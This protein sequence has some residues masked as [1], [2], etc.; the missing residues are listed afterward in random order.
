MFKYERNSN[1]FETIDTEE[2]AYWLGFLYADGYVNEKDNLIIVG[3]K[4]EDKEHI[5]KFQSFLQTN[6]PYVDKVNNGGR[7]YFFFR[8][9]DNKMFKDLYTQG[10][11]NK[12]YLTLEHNFNMPSELIIHWT[13][14]LFDGDGSIYP[15]TSPRAHERYYIGLVGTESI[16]KYTQ[17][18]WGVQRKLDYNRS[19]PKFTICRKEE[20]NRILHLLY[21][22]SNIFLDRKKNLAYKAIEINLQ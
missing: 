19:V 5:V 6:A 11:Y 1:V 21:D 7:P 15:H 17:Q 10:L 3:L 22:N 20:V 9:Y 14:G 12:K 13:R 18:V 8:L 2:K 16:L 4:H